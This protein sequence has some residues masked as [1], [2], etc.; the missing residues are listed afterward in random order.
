VPPPPPGQAALPPLI[1][2]VSSASRPDNA[3]VAV[4]YGKLWYSIG[5]DDLRSKTVFT[6]L[7]ILLT[8]SDTSDKGAAPQ[9]TIQAN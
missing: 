6:F 7:L 8:L 9:L 5:D 2:I 4:R 1:R 3:F